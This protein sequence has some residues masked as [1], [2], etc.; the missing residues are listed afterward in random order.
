MKNKHLFLSSVI[1]LISFSA[2]R[3]QSLRETDAPLPCKAQ[4]QIK[5]YYEANPQARLRH[6]K[7]GMNRRNSSARPD[8]YVIPV[9]FHVFGDDFKGSKVSDQLIIDALRRTNEDFQGLTA[10]WGDDNPDFDQRKKKLN[11]TFRLAEKDPHGN[12]TTGILYHPLEKG[13]GNYWNDRLPLYAWDNYSYMNV[14]LMLDLYGDGVTNNSGVSW[15]PDKEMSDRNLARVTYNPR[16]IGNN[17]DENFRRVLTHEFGHFLNLAHTFDDNYGK[18]PD[19]CS[20]AAD[21]TPNPGDWVDDTPAADRMM[22][23]ENDLNCKGEKTNWTNFMNY[24]D[25]YSMFTNGQ[26]ERMLD[27]LD[28]EARITLWSPE[29]RE[30]VFF[31]EAVPR[32]VIN[33]PA[34][35]E[36]S[37]N[38]GSFSEF[39]T[40]RILDG[41][42]IPH[43]TYTY[44]TDF[45]IEN[46][47][48]G[49]TGR[50]ISVS[51][52]E[53][54]LHLDGHATAHHAENNVTDLRL[55]V[56]D[57]VLTSGSF[58]RNDY[59][60]AL[61]F[62]D[63]YK[64]VYTQAGDITVSSAYTWQYIALSDDYEDAA[65][66]VFY[67]KGRL[68]IE[69]YTKPMV[70][71]GT[72]KQL[73]YVTY[74]ET[75]GKSSAWVP[76]EGYPNLHTLYTSSY[77]DW[78]GKLGFVGFQFKGHTDTDIL[79]GWMRISVAEDGSS[80]TLKD[81]AFN[82]E[83]GKD[84][85]AGQT[86]E[87]PL[88]ATLLLSSNT[89][90]EDALAND[91]SIEQIVTLTILGDNS[92]A[93]TG[94]Q[95]EGT[96]YLMTR[97]PQGL[98]SQLEIISSEQ[99]VLSFT[100]KAVAH[101]ASNQTYGRIELMPELFSKPEI[102]NRR[103]DIDYV[104]FDAYGIVSEEASWYAGPDSPWQYFTLSGIDAEYGA[105]IFD[106]SRLK[107]QTYSK[108]GVCYPGTAN[109]QPLTAGTEIGPD[110]P[111]KTPADEYENVLDL[112][113]PDF[114]EWE[115]KTAYAGLRIPYQGN[116]LY[117][118][119][120]ITVSADGTRFTVEE[121]AYNED[122]KGR[123]Y[124]GQTEPEAGVT[125]TPDQPIR[126]YPNPA[127][128]TLFV[129]TDGPSEIS[130]FALNGTPVKQ[131]TTGETGFMSIN[132]SELPAGL[133]FIK[134]RN[135]DTLLVKK[136]IIR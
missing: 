4:E 38:D 47:P 50:L 105:W 90:R 119:L 107:L 121:W 135:H 57:G 44:G 83:P 86:E 136:I 106:A 51:D 33:S 1:L 120:K 134:I 92:F 130:L 97:M 62:K 71:T 89:I 12:A 118:W 18:F 93:R 128:E 124:A 80:F 99:A 8:S 60:L 74:G 78:C 110:S 112:R 5:A 19:G 16:Y 100:G 77:K 9:V 11:V 81:Y 115:G 48:A 65:F 94:K 75:I 133:Y 15:Y 98:V 76:G 30:K 25:R 55:T 40:I 23:K 117:G 21:G 41:T 116:D 123:I 73:K 3:A 114:T 26:V 28:H 129:S 59:S 10:N 39:F 56:N 96:D 70:G 22:M 72:D 31:S 27:A 87:N 49:L 67:D 79:Y 43:A 54:Q 84:I 42:V 13:F 36:S 102:E 63:T 101:E 32:L 53:L 125:E 104:F 95:T 68:I 14:Y 91:G 127:T 126:I 66:G 29:N 131:E 6:E 37:A 109:L 7:P 108:P 64:I 58:Y 113:T 61:N 34:I 52:Q 45:T 46:L 82:E 24:T 17:T 2:I 122:P 20:P 132:V 35:T 111:W 69:S 85:L 103:Q 88:K